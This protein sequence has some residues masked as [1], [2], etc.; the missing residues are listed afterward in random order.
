MEDQAQGGQDP[1]AA[2]Q[3]IQTAMQQLAEGIGDKAPPQ[4]MQALQSAMSAYGEFLQIVTGGPQAD[5]GAVPA[6]GGAEN[7][8]GNPNA[9][10][11]R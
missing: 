4:A 2:L 11:V 3:G 10:P 1:M 6:P 8:G 5:K 7:Q 9:M